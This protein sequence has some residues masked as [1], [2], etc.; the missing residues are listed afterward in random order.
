MWRFFFSLTCLWHL[1]QW[2]TTS[3]LRGSTE[4]LP[5]AMQMALDWIRSYLKNR[6]QLI[7]T[8]SADP[9]TQNVSSGVPQGSV[10]GPI[11]FSVYVAEIEQ[12]VARHG[13]HSNQYADDTQIYAFCGPLLA[14]RMAECFIDVAS[15][16]CSNR[17]R[18]NG[19]KTEAIWFHPVSRSMPTPSVQLSGV[20][21]TPSAVVRNLGVYL[22]TS[23]S[24]ENHAGK[25]A[26]ACFSI[27]RVLRDAR[28]SV[29][30]EVLTTLVIQ[31]VLTKLD[32][33]NSV[34]YGSRKWALHKLQV[35]T[36]TAARPIFNARL[37]DHVS[38][39]LDDL[40]WLPITKRIPY[41]V[42]LMS[43]KLI[44]IGLPNTYKNSSLQRPLNKGGSRSACLTPLILS[45][46]GP[47]VCTTEADPSIHV[48]R[49]RGMIFRLMSDRLRH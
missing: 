38:P 11:L 28:H 37:T 20:S 24:M 10:L 17:L 46:Q 21:I 22:D 27:L 40:H 7:V 16:T 44:L 2:I 45:P 9:V 39:L 8:E 47:A 33:C 30:H 31:L 29:P 15:W 23:L 48:D 12:L 42:A 41:K 35:V 3:S 18:L 5:Y 14:L 34:L 19:G 4:H 6:S 43:T 32:Y 49:G 26:A 25:I 13:F 1:I 36:N